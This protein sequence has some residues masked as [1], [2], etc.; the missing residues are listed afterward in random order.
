MVTDSPR[1]PPLPSIR[2]LFGISQTDQLSAIATLPAPDPAHARLQPPR[3]ALVQFSLSD[4]HRSL[5]HPASTPPKHAAPSPHWV[6]STPDSR[7]PK[8]QTPSTASTSSLRTPPTLASPA[9]ATR[10]A[11]HADHARARSF[12][13]TSEGCDYP[14]TERQ[15][16]RPQPR[17]H[18]AD[19][20]RR[21]T[22]MAIAA[23]APPPPA[24]SS[25]P[26]EASA[27][28][29]RRVSSGSSVSVRSRSRSPLAQ[30]VH[31]S[32]KA[33]GEAG[34][35]GE[36]VLMRVHH[37]H[38]HGE[39]YEFTKEFLAAKY[40]CQ[41]CGKRFNR[42]SSLKVRLVPVLAGYMPT[43][44]QI[45]VNTHTGEKPYKCSFP[46]CGRRFSV[47][48]NMRRHSRVHAHQ[49]APSA[50]LQPTEAWRGVSVSGSEDDDEGGA[51]ASGAESSM[52][53]S[54]RMRMAGGGGARRSSPLAR[55]H[56]Y[57]HARP[58]SPRGQGEDP[59]MGQSALFRL[60]LV[61]HYAP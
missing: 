36:H 13:D 9:T 32:S 17:P 50:G 25:A 53:E 40:E 54:P 27:Q 49:S 55:M 2:T 38:P 14:D 19:L 44:V 35:G 34:F 45:H 31:P 21:P 7:A 60:P 5:P 52:S 57:A 12:S 16:H 51:S 28:H 47:M 37:A 1:Q 46:S 18:A 33:P 24:A 6:A 41:Y 8:P 23:R 15:D 11:R 43:V 10:Y 3:A 42:P 22:T 58:E 61:P 20:G 48:S 39:G 30:L 59:G 26:R 4:L 56:P 29:Q